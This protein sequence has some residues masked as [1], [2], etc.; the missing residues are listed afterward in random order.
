MGGVIVR[1]EYRV[2]A[3]QGIESGVLEA[4][5]REAAVSLIRG[6][7][8]VPLEIREVSGGGGLKRGITLFKPKPKLKD[9]ALAFRQLATMIS[10][11]ITVAGALGIIKEQVQNRALAKAFDNVSRGVMSGRGLADAMA[12][13]ST[14]SP[15]VVSIVRAGEEGGVLDL[16]L[17]RLATLLEK[18]EALRRKISSA[19]VYPMVVLCICVMVL[20]IL[21]FVIIPR[22]S[23]V[24]NQMGI[25][26]P[27]ITRIVFA[28]ANG[29]RDNGLVI[30][31]VLLCLGVALGLLKKIPS[32]AARWD[33]AKL[34]FPLVGDVIYK[35]IMARS[36]RTFGTLISAGVPLLRC[37]DMASDVANNQFVGGAFKSLREGAE[38]GIPL[39]VKAKRDK[40]FPPMVCH[41]VAIGEETGKLEEMLEKV[42]D[43]Y[44]ME[45]EEKIKGL[46]SALEPMLIVF[47]GGVVA[48]VAMS[49]F[50]PIISAIQSLM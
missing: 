2:R 37:L 38:K 25:E 8:W 35:G 4:S 47:V 12:S 42:A 22:F 10:A 20:G 44:D 28:F 1:F 16:S 23:L 19:L 11:G 3:P 36:F 17:Q 21:V 41:M 30:M 29:A 7:G 39:N 50:F 46:T 15:L 18:Q 48:V 5:S 26:L 33:R 27:L 14:F 43:W 45:L 32:V 6:K 24:F 49:I 34:K 13:E 9:V 40:L 31:G